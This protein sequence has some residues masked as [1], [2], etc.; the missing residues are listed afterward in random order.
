MPLHLLAFTTRTYDSVYVDFPVTSK[1]ELSDER[2]V[3][4]NRYYT[5][6][7]RIAHGE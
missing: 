3:K 1:V 5:I 2:I 6:G 4:P 7:W